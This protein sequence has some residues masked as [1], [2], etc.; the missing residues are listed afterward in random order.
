M[1]N[2]STKTSS[3]TKFLHGENPQGSD[4]VIFPDLHGLDDEQRKNPLTD[5]EENPLSVTM[6]HIVF[7]PSFYHHHQACMQIDANTACE[8]VEW[9]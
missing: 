8:N 3:H 6:D 2:N 4:G 7:V 5:H 9:K 1:C